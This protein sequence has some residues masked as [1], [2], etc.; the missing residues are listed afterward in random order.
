MEFSNTKGFIQLDFLLQSKTAEQLYFQ[1]AEAMPVI[2]YHNHLSP[3]I[4]AKNQAFRDINAVWLDGDHYKW[5]AMRTLGIEEKFITGNASSKEK[6]D[7]WAKTVPY[8]VGN[9][10]F[11]W[12]HLELKRYFN[13]SDLLQPSSSDAIFEETN[14]QLK[15]LLPNQMLKNMKVEILCTTDDP[16]DDLK[17]HQQIKKN[18]FGPKVLP[19]FRPDKIFGIN[20]EDYLDYLNALADSSGVNINSLQTLLD[21]LKSRIT[22]FHENGCRI[23]DHGLEYTYASD[24][25]LKAVDASLKKRISGEKISEEDALAFNSC[26]LFE[27]FV[28]YHENG[29]TQQLHLGALRGNN[30]KLNEQLGAD[31]GCDSIGDFAQAKNLSKLLGKLNSSDKLTQTIIYNLNPAMNEVFASMPGNFNSSKV[32]IQWGTAWWFLDQKDGMETQMKALSNMGLLSRFIG[33]LTDSRS[34]MSFP[35]HEYFRRLLCN[36]IAEDIG[37]GLLPNDLPF[38]GKMIQD[39]CYNNLNNFLKIKN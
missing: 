1:Y 20:T 18:N 27:L 17:H 11:H 22:Y 30:Q 8:T 29:W 31:V 25:S 5:R 21:A 28:M 24:Y 39:I 6:F 3:E 7:Q 34:F 37:Q 35:R 15:S 19:G 16:I 38:F 33:M 32:E 13:I 4:I 2:D 12:T 10:L 9:P 23:S 26:V 14:H 36:M